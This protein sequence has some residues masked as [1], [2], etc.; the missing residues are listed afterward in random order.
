MQS[1]YDAAFDK[2]GDWID[3]LRN[4][5]DP[6]SW[7]EIDRYF[8][9]D[10]DLLDEISDYIE[11]PVSLEEWHVLVAIQKQKEDSR[12][13]AEIASGA[14]IVKRKGEDSVFTVPDIRGSNWQLYK[15]R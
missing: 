13:M 1:L 11:K 2:W 14:G 9:D 4:G 12:Y 15:K 10:L 6:L 8:D 5:R 3:D 7:E